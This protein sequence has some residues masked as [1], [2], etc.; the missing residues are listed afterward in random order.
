MRQV[1]YFTVITPYV[2]IAVFLWRALT[3]EGAYD[4]LRF[5]FQPRWELLMDAKAS[6]RWFNYTCLVCSVR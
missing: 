3:L 2:L 4:G 5:L 1:V 6:H